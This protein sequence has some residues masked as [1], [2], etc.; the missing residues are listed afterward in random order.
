MIAGN[1]VPL[2][3]RKTF[4]NSLILEAKSLTPSLYKLLRSA[5]HDSVVLQR[6]KVNTPSLQI[7]DQIDWSDKL[8][9]LLIPNSALSGW[10]FLRWPVVLQGL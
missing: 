3:L 9:Y 4:V 10:S 1:I 2:H 7:A 5:K 6:L 8:S